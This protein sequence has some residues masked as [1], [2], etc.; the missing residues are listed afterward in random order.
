MAT[1]LK[2]PVV[3][4]VN[5]WCR[6]GLFGL[7][8]SSNRPLMVSLE[9]GPIIS[10]REKGCRKTYDLDIETAFNLA[11]RREVMRQDAKKR[12][13]RKATGRKKR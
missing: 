13:K 1:K 9:P 8:S 5:D 12:K 3:R 11:V 10:F 4:E 6:K 7:G 2:K